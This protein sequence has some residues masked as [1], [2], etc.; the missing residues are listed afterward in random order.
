MTDDRK[1][2]PFDRRRRTADPA[3]VREFAVTA[4]RLQKEREDS[5][6]RS[7]IGS[8]ARPRATNGRD[9]PA[10]RRCATAACSIV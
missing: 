7:S 2:V 3:R 5:A 9:L 10:I 6:R 1:L 8:C 4:R